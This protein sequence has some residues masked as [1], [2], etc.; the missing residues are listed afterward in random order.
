MKSEEEK[1]EGGAFSEPKALHHPTGDD[2]QEGLPSQASASSNAAPAETK[3]ENNQEPPTTA[4]AGRGS[5]RRQRLGRIERVRAGAQGK[6]EFLL[7]RRTPAQRFV[8]DY[9]LQRQRN[10]PGKKARAQRQQAVSEAAPHATASQTCRPPWM[11]ARRMGRMAAMGGRA[12]VRRVVL[13]LV[14]GLPRSSGGDTS[15][16]SQSLP[17]WRSRTR[18]RSPRQT[19]TRAPGQRTREVT[20][21]SEQAA[22]SEAMA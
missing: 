13:Q 1:S 12:L 17:Q 2:T 10:R 7:E 18:T 5:L 11:G 16:T 9:T 6:G 3:E 19:L 14:G 8:D 22:A 15:E 4:P 21:S 20:L